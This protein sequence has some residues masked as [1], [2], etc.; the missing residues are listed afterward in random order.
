MYAM[1]Y[2]LIDNINNTSLKDTYARKAKGKV[3]KFVSICVSIFF[4]SLAVGVIYS[5][6]HR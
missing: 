5:N 4:L 3:T 6:Y 2:G 1:I